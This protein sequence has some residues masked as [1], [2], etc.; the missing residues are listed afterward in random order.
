MNAIWWTSQDIR[1]LCIFLQNERRV[2][3]LFYLII[4][5]MQ[6]E[7]Y[8]TDERRVILWWKISYWKTFDKISALLE[9][10]IKK[11]SIW[12]S[13]IREIELSYSIT[14]IKETV[15]FLCWR[16]LVCAINWNIL[17]IFFSNIRIITNRFSFF[18]ASISEFVRLWASHMIS[19]QF[20]DLEICHYCVEDWIYNITLVSF[21]YVD[22]F[23]FIQKTRFSSHSKTKMCWKKSDSRR[24][25]K[26]RFAERK[27]IFVAFE[28]LKSRK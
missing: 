9:C 25:W 7:D 12:A 5:C 3:I 24:I 27:V 23:I 11:N 18:N 20:K 10:A 8:D 1:T 2:F 19:T 15:E 14:W 26:R 13:K 22:L 28:Y 16:I 6:S 21:S 4:D 17:T